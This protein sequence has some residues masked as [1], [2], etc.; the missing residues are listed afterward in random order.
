MFRL[1]SRGGNKVFGYVKVFSLING[2]L[3]WFQEVEKQFD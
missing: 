1:D 3:G 2:N